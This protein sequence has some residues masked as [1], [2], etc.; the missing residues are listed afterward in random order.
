MNK[1]SH[2][3]DEFKS[4]LAIAMET[5][6]TRFWEINLDQQQFFS[7]LFYNGESTEIVKPWCKGETLEDFIHPQDTHLVYQLI[8]DAIEDAGRIFNAR[9]RIL[10]INDD[11][12]WEWSIVSAKL[13]ENDIFNEQAKQQIIA[14]SIQSIKQLQETENALSQLSHEYESFKQSQEQLVELAKLSSLSNLVTGVAHE[15]NTP[16]GICISSISHVQENTSQIEDK[17]KNN[18]LSKSD[19]ESLFTDIQQSLGLASKNINKITDLIGSFKQVSVDQH[20]ESPHQIELRGLITQII[21]GYTSKLKHSGTILTFDGNHLIDMCS[22]PKTIALILGHFINNSL[23]H[24]FAQQSH[25]DINIEISNTIS[26]LHDDILIIYKDNGCGV[27][28][29]TLM[30]LFAPFSVTDA[31]SGSVGLGLHIVHNL[32]TQKL[33]GK[34]VANSLEGHGLELYLRLPREIA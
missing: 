24:G 6:G 27:C 23:I 21:K 26:E 22:Y 34:I 12:M 30:N 16:I 13:V 3:Q 18:K 5:S 9:C 2:N 29:A 32:V 14:G 19:L 28:P 31:K 33:K 17:F 4:R 8:E 25:G 1:I 11:S 15:L 7:Y 20:T 10:S